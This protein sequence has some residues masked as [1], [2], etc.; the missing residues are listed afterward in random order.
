V[1]ERGTRQQRR[2]SGP[3]E[4]RPVSADRRHGSV[5]LRRLPQVLRLQVHRGEPHG[6]EP[7]PAGG[8]HGELVERCARLSVRIC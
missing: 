1:V 5:R 4:R 2:V 6:P 3:P 7:D 8:G